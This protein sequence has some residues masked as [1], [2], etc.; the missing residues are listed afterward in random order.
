MQLLVNIDVADLA[1]AERFYCRAFDLTV[2]RRLGPTAA[3]LRG[4]NAAI[5]LLEKP[6][7]SIASSATSQRRDYA[8]HW[9]PVHLDVVVDDLDAAIAR[10]IDAGAIAEGTP[11]TSSWGRIAQFADPFG[12][13]FCILQFL[14]R[15]YDEI[16]QPRVAP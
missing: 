14:G 16:A 4:A 7:G 9:T 13:G 12:N 5:Y 3:E 6:A 1:Q 8:R 15:G 10:A 11:R 2:S